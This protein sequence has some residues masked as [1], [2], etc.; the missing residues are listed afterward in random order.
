MK[1]DIIA[2]FNRNRYMYM[3][4]AYHKLKRKLA[5]GMIIFY[6]GEPQKLKTFLRTKMSRRI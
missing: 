2:N 3:N 5:N 6:A 4:Q 1:K